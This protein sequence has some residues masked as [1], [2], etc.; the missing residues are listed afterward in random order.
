MERTFTAYQLGSK[1]YVKT[2]SGSNDQTV[3]AAPFS[4]LSIPLA[5]L[6]LPK[7]RS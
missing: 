6:W 1:G 2:A 4:T 5:R 3:Q 7:R